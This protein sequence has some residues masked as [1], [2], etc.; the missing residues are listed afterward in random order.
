MHIPPS[1][2]LEIFNISGAE[3]EGLH[4]YAIVIRMDEAVLDHNA[5][6]SENIDAIRA[7]NLSD[8]RDIPNAHSVAFRRNEH[9]CGG[10]DE[11][12]A[13]HH[14]IGAGF[15][16]HKRVPAPV[17]VSFDDPVPANGESIAIP[18][19]QWSPKHG[20]MLDAKNVYLA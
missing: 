14:D 8:K 12:D 6:A 20:S 2:D 18:D 4:C 16:H 3:V 11:G 10:A 1:I 13:L 7:A 5:G 19:M 9:P 15:K 17:G